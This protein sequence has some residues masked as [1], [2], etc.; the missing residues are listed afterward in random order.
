M[1]HNK[2]VRDKIPQICRDNGD[3]PTTRILDES[4]YKKELDKKLQEEV[5]EYNQDDNLEELADILEVVYAIADQKG[6]SREELE[7]LRAKKATER[8]GFKDR[9]FLVETQKS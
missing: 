2:L 6:S 7:K 4:E 8:G 5:A 9:V 3:E 1:Q